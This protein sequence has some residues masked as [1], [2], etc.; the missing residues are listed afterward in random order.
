VV[1]WRMVGD[2]DWRGVSMLMLMLMLAPLMLMLAPLMLMLTVKSS[3][4][5]KCPTRRVEKCV[6]RLSPVKNINFSYWPA[7]CYPESQISKIIV[8]LQLHVD[9]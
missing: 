7:V 6:K 5:G 1:S 8:L 9:C 3:R 2:M 4:H